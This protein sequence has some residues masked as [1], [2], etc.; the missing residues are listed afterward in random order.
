MQ[1]EFL[2]VPGMSVNNG[3]NDFFIRQAMWLI[4]QQDAPDDFVIATGEAHSVRD[5]VQEA[6]KCVGV[7]ILW[8]GEGAFEVGK[9]EGS[10][11]VRVRVNLQFYRPTEPVITYT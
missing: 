2:V 11:I 10:G 4:L 7:R 3:L 1:L 9:E 6:F 5:F 8:E